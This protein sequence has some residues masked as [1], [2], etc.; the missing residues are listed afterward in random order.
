V[1]AKLPIYQQRG[2][3][4]IWLIHPYDRLV[5]VW[6]RQLDG[7]Y[8]SSIHDAGVIELLA[9]PGVVIDVAELFL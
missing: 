2:D 9:L 7:T 5:T 6:R 1:K 8:E 3:A 4:E